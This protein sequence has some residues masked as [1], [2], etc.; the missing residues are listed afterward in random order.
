MENPMDVVLMPCRH[1][2]LCRQCSTRVAM[3]PICRKTIADVIEVF[4]S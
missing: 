1:M 2:V 4:T 3:C